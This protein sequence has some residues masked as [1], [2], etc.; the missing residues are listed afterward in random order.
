ME[1]LCYYIF[2]FSAYQLINVYKVA[3]VTFW[4]IKKMTHFLIKSEKS[5][6]YGIICQLCLLYCFLFLDIIFTFMSARLFITL[7]GSWVSATNQLMLEK[8]QSYF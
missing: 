8:N 4:V 1:S 5:C 6:P 2:P 3:S 7:A